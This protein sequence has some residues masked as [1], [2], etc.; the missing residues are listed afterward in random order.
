MVE[1]WLADAH[2]RGV[3]SDA[4]KTT[5]LVN[6]TFTILSVELKELTELAELDKEGKPKVRQTYVGT[7]RFDGDPENHV[8]WLGG[9]GPKAAIDEALERGAFPLQVKLVLDGKAYMLV[10]PTPATATAA[11]T[12][13]EFNLEPLIRDWVREIGGMGEVQRVFSAGTLMPPISAALAYSPMGDLRWRL[14]SLDSQQK[15]NLWLALRGE[16]KKPVEEG[17]SD[18]DDLDAMSFD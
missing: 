4:I 17:P 12:T 13:A 1:D 18:E 14:S 2:K 5:E 3:G 16:W 6:R 9:A 11:P 7:I 15:G 8:A 10:R